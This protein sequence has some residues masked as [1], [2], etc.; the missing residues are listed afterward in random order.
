[1]TKRKRSDKMD[2]RLSITKTFQED[3][4]KSLS[5]IEQRRHEKPLHSTHGCSIKLRDENFWKE[6]TEKSSFMNELLVAYKFGIRR[7]IKLNKMLFKSLAKVMKITDE[8][9]GS[10]ILNSKDFNK[11]EKELTV[12]S[13]IYHHLNY[14]K[15]R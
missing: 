10:P 3:F 5:E 8:L 11:L 6:A 9:N 13:R 1:M 4:K 15:K 12:M 7:Q 2:K 14:S